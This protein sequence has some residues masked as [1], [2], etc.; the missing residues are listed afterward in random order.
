[1]YKRDMEIPYLLKSKNMKNN[2]KEI[3]YGTPH[4][5][6]PRGPIPILCKEYKSLRQLPRRS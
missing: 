5:K 1:M 6:G 2:N 4:K 3:D